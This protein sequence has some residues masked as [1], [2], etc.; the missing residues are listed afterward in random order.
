MAADEVATEATAQADVGNLAR[1]LL[2]KVMVLLEEL[3][4]RIERDFP[5]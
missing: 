2:A 5:E 3:A 1:E 4:K